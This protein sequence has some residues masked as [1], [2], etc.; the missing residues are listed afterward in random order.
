[1]R[2]NISVFLAQ[3]AAVTPQQALDGRWVLALA[4]VG[5]RSMSVELEIAPKKNYST[6]CFSML[7]TFAG[8]HFTRSTKGN[9][10]TGQSK[11]WQTGH[12]IVLQSSM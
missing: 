10:R 1:M 12:E 7:V 2:R 9:S 8:V 4:S 5:A 6:V 11:I 3:I